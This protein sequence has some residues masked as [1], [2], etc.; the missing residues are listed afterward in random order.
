[1]SKVTIT[2]IVT[3]SSTS[4]KPLLRQLPRAMITPP[5]AGQVETLAGWGRKHN[6]TDGCG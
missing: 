4:V 3:I 6:K 5:N 1:M 2:A